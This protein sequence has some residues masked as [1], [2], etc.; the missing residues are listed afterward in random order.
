MK[1]R[2]RLHKAGLRK[3]AEERQEA[4]SRLS[5]SEKVARL[6]KRLGKGSGAKRERARLNE[7]H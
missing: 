3:E 5:A 6:N 1:N 2:G 4:S 7:N